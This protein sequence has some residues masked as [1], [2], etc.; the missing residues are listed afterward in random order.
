[1]RAFSFLFVYLNKA[2]LLVYIPLYGYANSCLRHD[3]VI[4]A[5]MAGL[6]YVQNNRDARR[7]GI[8]FPNFHVLSWDRRL[9][10]RGEREEYMNCG[11]GVN[12]IC[13]VN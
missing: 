5:L 8:K 1:V 7:Y 11:L 4:H 3:I 2:C 10:I 12:R 13:W 9:L 6:C